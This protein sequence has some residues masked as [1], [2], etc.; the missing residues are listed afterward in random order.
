MASDSS[1]VNWKT[2]KAYTEKLKNYIDQKVLC[3][4]S[5]CKLCNVT[6]YRPAEADILVGWYIDGMVT[7]GTHEIFIVE[8][9]SVKGHVKY[10]V[11]NDQTKT[12]KYTWLDG[13]SEPSGLYCLSSGAQ[14]SSWGLLFYYVFKMVVSELSTS[15]TG[16]SK[17]K[18]ILTLSGTDIR[19]YLSVA[20]RYSLYW[21]KIS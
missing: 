18:R 6:T 13:T 20:S 12:I 1:N 21:R 15:A 2:I 7:I 19:N 8:G 3:V 5:D 17:S 4:P 10:V 9:N 11:K 16:E 14:A